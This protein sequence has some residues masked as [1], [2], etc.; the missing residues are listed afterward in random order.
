M[1]FVKDNAK[2]GIFFLY[3]QALGEIFYT[4]FKLLTFRAGRK[5][6]KPAQALL[7]GGLGRAFAL[8]RLHLA[9]PRESPWPSPGVTFDMTGQRPSAVDG[10]P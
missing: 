6:K 4:T 8:A 7:L 10:S 2:V 1:S 9:V 5:C 3:R